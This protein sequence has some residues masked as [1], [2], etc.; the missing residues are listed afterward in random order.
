MSFEQALD[1]QPKPG[2]QRGKTMKHI[3]SILVF[4]AVVLTVTTTA[5]GGIVSLSDKATTASTPNSLAAGSLESNSKLY[6]FAE[7]QQVTL[8]G[9]ITTD[10][11]QPGTYSWF[12]PSL[13]ASSSGTIAAGTVVDSYLLHFDPKGTPKWWKPKKISAGVTFDTP[14]L[15]IEVLSSSLA[16][17]DSPLG[18]PGTTYESGSGRGVEAFLQDRIT[19]SADLRTITADFRNASSVDEIRIITASA[20][21][22]PATCLLGVIGLVVFGWHRR[23]AHGRRD[24]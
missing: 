7:A 8:A 16:A 23:R 6:V 21:P 3:L 12:F 10:I 13:L 1:R 24:G 17:T 5:Q 20:V 11:A 4:S 18:L 2:D 19:L 9:S 14:I 22:E 15:G